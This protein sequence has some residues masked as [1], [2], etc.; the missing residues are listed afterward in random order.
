M[1][2][3]ISQN[4]TKNHHFKD[5]RKIDEKNKNHQQREF[6]PKKNNLSENFP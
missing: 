3:K 1:L 4:Q 6:S 5:P 2:K